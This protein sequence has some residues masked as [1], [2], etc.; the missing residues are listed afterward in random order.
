MVSSI[1]LDC[2]HLIFLGVSKKLLQFWIK[3]KL[4]I[5][6]SLVLLEKAERRNNLLKLLIPKEFARHPRILLDIDR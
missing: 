3:G 5:R 1:L 4:N 2:M 6:L